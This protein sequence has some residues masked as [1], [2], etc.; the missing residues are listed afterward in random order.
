[1]P[2]EVMKA[3]YSYNVTLVEK[4]PM[5]CK[6]MLIGNNP[7]LRIELTYP[8]GQSDFQFFGSYKYT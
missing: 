2:P 7:P 6:I 8:Y 5:T 3:G 1:M 4:I